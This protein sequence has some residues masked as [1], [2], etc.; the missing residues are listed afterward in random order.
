[1]WKSFVLEPRE[2]WAEP[3]DECIG[4]KATVEQR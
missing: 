2:E 1:M 4:L 3:V